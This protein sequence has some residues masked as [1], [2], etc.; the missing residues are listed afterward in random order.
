MNDETK[1]KKPGFF[2]RMFGRG[3][4]EA[5]TPLETPELEAPIPAPSEPSAPPSDGVVA[6]GCGPV[7]LTAGELINSARRCFNR[8]LTDGG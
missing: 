7:G 1:E 4:A 5:A 8:W 2:G 3:K 6:E